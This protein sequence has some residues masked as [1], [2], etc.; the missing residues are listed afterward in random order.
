MT[1]GPPRRPI[2]HAREEMR[3]PAAAAVV[4]RGPAFSNGRRLGIEPAPQRKNPSNLLKLLGFLFMKWLREPA[5]DVANCSVGAFGSMKISVSP[6]HPH[7]QVRKPI[8]A[9]FPGLTT[10][11]NRPRKQ[12]CMSRIGG[13]PDQAV[14]Q[15]SITWSPKIPALWAS[16][17]DSHQLLTAAWEPSPVR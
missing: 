3:I 6:P 7:P 1:S 9:G 11:E 16:S 17:P 14:V 8:K 2:I 4:G 10:G 13:R 15:R 5:V 12:R